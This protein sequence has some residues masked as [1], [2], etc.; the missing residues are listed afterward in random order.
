MLS[1]RLNN[2]RSV[3]VHAAHILASRDASVWLEWNALIV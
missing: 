3:K 2:R 1:K